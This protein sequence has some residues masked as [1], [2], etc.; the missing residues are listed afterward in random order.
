MK[1][2]EEIFDETASALKVLGHPTR[3]QILAI[4]SGTKGQ[5]LS[6]TDIHEKLDIGQPEASKHLITMRN[7]GVLKMEKRDGFSFYRINQ[8]LP[9]LQPLIK[10]INAAK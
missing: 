7:Q 6:V 4:L 1:V 3:L 9:Y 5:G 10:F 8:E 2:K